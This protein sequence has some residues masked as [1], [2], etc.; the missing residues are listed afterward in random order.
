MTATDEKFV[1]THDAILQAGQKLFRQKGYRGTSLR[2]VMAA[3]GLTVGGFYAHFGSKSDLFR[4]C[5]EK[6][7]ET[8]FARVMAGAGKGEFLKPVQR[9]LGEPHIQAKAEGCPLAAMLSEL[10]QL[11]EDGP[12]PMV[13]DYLARFGRE[14]ARLG[15]DK[16]R[17]FALISMMVGAL[18]LA[19]AVT[20][21]KLKEQLVGQALQAAKSFAAEKPSR[22]NK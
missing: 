5:F 12:L 9:Y 20:G 1:Q 17:V 3:A 19:R 10:D 6:A 4:T 8:G 2:D 18:A 7:G 11:K 13:D 15:A 21:T 16:D 22:E 14:L